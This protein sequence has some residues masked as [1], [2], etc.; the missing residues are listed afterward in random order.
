LDDRR[1]W[2]RLKSQHPNEAPPRPAYNDLVN[3]PSHYKSNGSRGYRLIEAF[4]ANE[5]HYPGSNWAL[6]S[7]SR[8]RADY[9]SST[10]SR[11]WRRLSGTCW[12]GTE[13]ERL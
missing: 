5:Q 9:K 10:Q 3:H 6:K 1:G 8:L 11:I 2:D 13:I 4:A 12:T 7:T